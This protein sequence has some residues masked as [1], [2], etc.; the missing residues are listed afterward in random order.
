MKIDATQKSMDAIC[1]PDAPYLG[2]RLAARKPTGVL[3]SQ[4]YLEEDG[5]D[6]VPLCH[7]DMAGVVVVVGQVSLDYNSTKYLSGAA[8]V[9][10]L[11]DAIGPGQASEFLS[12]FGPVYFHSLRISEYYGSAGAPQSGTETPELVP[13]GVAKGAG[14]MDLDKLPTQVLNAAFIAIEQKYTSGVARADNPPAEMRKQGREIFAVLQKRVPNLLPTSILLKDPEPVVKSKPVLS[15]IVKR[16][17][18]EDPDWMY[19]L[20]MVLEPNDGQDGVD[21]NP[22]FDGEI[23]DRHL[24]R[25]MAFPYV[26]KY[27]GLGIMHEGERLEDTDARVVQSYVV[28]DGF[29]LTDDSG[30]D[31]GPGVW[32]LGTE[33]KRASDLGQRI[34]SGELGA[35]SIDGIALKVPEKVAA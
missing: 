9:E 20:S 1:L 13:G 5:W 30:K 10:G 29:T 19:V 2:D 18:S 8:A 26:T 17:D 7:I 24:I 23:Y 21:L 11:K 3:S 28:D 22:D 25:K 6:G 35:Y 32:F 4:A 12:E 33:V 16:A 27:R 14:P 34:E 31:W 15:R